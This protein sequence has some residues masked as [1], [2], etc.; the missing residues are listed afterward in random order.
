MSR[1]YLQGLVKKNKSKLQE[2]QDNADEVIGKYGEIFS[3]NNLHSLTADDFRSF[4]SFKNN[5]HWTGIHRS[6][7]ILTKDMS[8]LRK[9]LE[10]LLDESR[11]LEKRL[12]EIF[13]KKKP[14][15][16][17]GLGK[18]VTTPILHVVYPKKYGIYNQKGEDALKLLELYPDL[19]NGNS[20]AEQYIA[21]NNLLLKLASE[22][23]ISLWQLDTLW[24]ITLQ[25]NNS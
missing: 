21:V 24:H 18:A 23:N 12:N 3:P 1:I 6:S 25:D 2:W 22:L 19:Q 10:I 8:N 5:K 20:F 11:P 17:K 7:G 9:V 16:I 4:L 14:S 15:M 13:P